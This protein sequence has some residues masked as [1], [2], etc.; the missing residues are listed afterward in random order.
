MSLKLCWQAK[1]SGVTAKLIVPFLDAELVLTLVDDVIIDTD[2]QLSKTVQAQNHSEFAKQIYHFLL[3]P[4]DHHLEV[5]L[6]LQGTEYSQKVWNALVDIP[7][8]QVMSYS[9]LATQLDSG[10]RA[11]AQ[12]CRNNPYP[13]LIPCHRV[14]ST[15]GIGG[16][17]GQTKGPCVELKRQLLNYELRTALIKP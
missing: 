1:V 17:M 6:L 14:V 16:F 4:I 3:N 7:F 2:W 12:A 9:Q 11:V 15:S 8:G 5:Q 13:G 10:P